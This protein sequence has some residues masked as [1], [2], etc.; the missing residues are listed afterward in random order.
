MSLYYYL[1]FFLFCSL[2]YE[3]AL[4]CLRGCCG[5]LFVYLF[6]CIFVT[7]VGAF[8]RI[9]IRVFVYEGRVV[10]VAPVVVL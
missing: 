4:I 6:G 7:Y 10:S 8:A 3:F 9:D 2:R 1:S 5:Y